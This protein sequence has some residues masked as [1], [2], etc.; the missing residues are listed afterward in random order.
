MLFI[1]QSDLYDKTGQCTRRTF[2]ER[3]CF[4]SLQPHAMVDYAS[5]VGQIGLG[6]GRVL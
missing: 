2:L 6:L 5:G 4:I 1:I 3:L